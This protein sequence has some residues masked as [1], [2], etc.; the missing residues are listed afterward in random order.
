MNWDIIAGNW[1][2]LRGRLLQKIGEFNHDELDVIAGK[3][4]QLSGRIQVQ[5]GLI[6]QQLETD[7]DLFL[8]RHR[9]D[10]RH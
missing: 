3:R 7:V 1:K 5:Y 9:P 4:A 8:T 2:Q 10:Q 6:R